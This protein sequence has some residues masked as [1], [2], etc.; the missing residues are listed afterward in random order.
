MQILANHTISVLFIPM[1]KMS[2][3]ADQPELR[4]GYLG[5]CAIF[6]NAEPSTYAQLLSLIA[7][8]T[9]LGGM[10]QFLTF[11]FLRR[12]QENFGKAISYHFAISLQIWAANDLRVFYYLISKG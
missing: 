12:L 5:A 11:V 10:L 8:L 6:L 7:S 4:N 1:T 3:L 9:M 2:M